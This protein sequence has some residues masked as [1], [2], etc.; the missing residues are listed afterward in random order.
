MIEDPIVRSMGE[1]NREAEHK[2]WCDAKLL[3]KE[4]MS[5]SMVEVV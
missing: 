1:A 2:G 5:K 3:T 4:L